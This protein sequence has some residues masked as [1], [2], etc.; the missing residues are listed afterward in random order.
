MDFDART[1]RES[2]QGFLHFIVEPAELQK[3][4]EKQRQENKAEKNRLIVQE[5]NVDSIE[6][7]VRRRKGK[8]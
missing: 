2:R 1:K 8:N 4:K 5:K 3:F 6:R 7:E